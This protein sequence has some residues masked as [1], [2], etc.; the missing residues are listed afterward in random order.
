MIQLVFV[1]S[2]SIGVVFMIVYDLGMDTLL[3]C[4]IVDETS[5]KEKG[6]KALYAPEE[7]AELMD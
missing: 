6:G 2:Y 4:F 5:Q 1:Y 3:M 7:L